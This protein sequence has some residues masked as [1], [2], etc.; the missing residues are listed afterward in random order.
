M[1]PF[2]S[3]FRRCRSLLALSVLALATGVGSAAAS[4]ATAA[5]LPQACSLLTRAEA[6]VLAGVKLQRPNDLGRGLGCMYTGYPTG[7]VAQVEL[8][9]DS[10]LPRTLQIDRAVLHHAFWKVPR[11]GDQALEEQGYIFVRKG[12]VWITLHVI[13]PDVWP[14]PRKRLERAARIAISRVKPAARRA[15]GFRSLAGVSRDPP[16]GGGRERWTGVER[17]YGGGITRYDGVVF[18]PSVVLIG[19]GARAIR[20]ASPDGL[21]W[22]IDA[23]APGASDLSVGKIML[24]T[25][26]ATGRVLELTRDGS[27]LRVVLGP[28]ALTDIVRNGEFRS[29]APVPVATPVVYKTTL[30]S[31]P[32]KKRRTQSAAKLSGG[33][34]GTAT[35]ICCEGGIGVH[36]YYHNAAGKLSATIQLYAERPSVDFH[37]RIGGGKLIESGFRL[38]GV[39]GL[40]Y[41]ISGAT[42]NGSGNFRTGPIAVPGALTIPLVGPLAITITQSFDASMQ[43]VG[44]ASL[45]TTGDYR[46]T[47]ALG[48]GY[49]GG[50]LKREA[51]TMET[52]TPMSEN[53]LSLGIASNSVSIG[54]ALRA[55]VGIGAVVFTAG[56]WGELRAGLALTGDGSHLQSLTFGCTTV[57]IDVKAKFGVGF[58]VADF[59][60]API[61]ALLGLAHIK[62]IPARGGPEWGP[63]TVWHPPNSQWC[64]PRR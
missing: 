18:Q 3:E 17:R 56:A 57:A 24:A 31:K 64:P 52:K 30:P 5:A 60:R 14:G 2:H 49:D 20:S 13:S 29:M 39:G 41:E 48:F 19:G 4:R 25:T 8:Y 43:L 36:L 45:K 58:S 7:P 54:Y 26:L 28:V 9:V 16:A 38:R 33:A 35:P 11:L 53:T 42:D 21:T 62:P 44:Q 59:V 55:T 12:S 10:S 50:A 6:Q 51:L 37:I 47:G 46:F 27:N 32:S 22:T 1:R 34:A 40:K 23:T 15:A 61:N 63:F